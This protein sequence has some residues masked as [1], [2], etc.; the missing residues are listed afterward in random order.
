M[1][2]Y[3]AVVP[4]NQKRTIALISSQDGSP[5]KFLDLFEFAVGPIRW[6]PDGQAIIYIREHGGTSNLYNQPIT[7]GPPEHVTT[8]SADHIFWFDWSPNGKQLALVRGL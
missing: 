8:F 5:I 3:R 2:A 1:I 7:G 6:T 4:P